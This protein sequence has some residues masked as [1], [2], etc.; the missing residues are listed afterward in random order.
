MNRRSDT[1]ILTN[2]YNCIR[3]YN[4]QR[5]NILIGG[6][7]NEELKKELPHYIVYYV[8]YPGCPYCIKFDELWKE[9]VKTNTFNNISIKF[10]TVTINS[11][12]KLAKPFEF[13]KKQIKLSSVP[14][15]VIYDK[16]N[17][18]IE[19]IEDYRNLYNH[20]SVINKSFSC[21]F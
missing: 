14:S 20:L 18:T 11:L 2:C 13:R 6:K 8:K 5:K 7:D 3:K 17:D 10:K 15:L 21:D 12:T 16:Q 1:M 9:I 19:E 4:E